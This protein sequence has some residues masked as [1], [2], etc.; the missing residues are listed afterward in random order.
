[1]SESTKEKRTPVPTSEILKV[2]IPAANTGKTRD[3]IADKLGMDSNSL[4]VRLSTIRK[5]LK[6]KGVEL[7]KL[8]G[9]RATTDWDELAEQA[10]T[11]M[12]GTAVI[13]DVDEDF[14]E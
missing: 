11:L 9:T 7:P 6:A 13:D 4:G 12:G 10:K 14:D 3:E 5:Q 2:Y 8:K 1:M